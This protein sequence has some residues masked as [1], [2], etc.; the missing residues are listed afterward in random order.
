MLFEGGFSFTNFVAD[1]FAVFMFVV[2]FWLLVTVASDLFRR[3]DV[4]GLGKAAWVILLLVLPYIG[5]FAYLLSQGRGMSER[6]EQ[7]V[8]R[9]RNDLRHVVGFSAADE[10]AKLESLKSTGAISPEEYTRLRARV[11]Q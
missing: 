3:G 6:H 7:Q 8:Q 5:V 2:W 9:A 10:I 1:V 4:S 11:V